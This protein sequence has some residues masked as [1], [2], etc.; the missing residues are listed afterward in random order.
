MPIIH[1][2]FVWVIPAL[3]ALG[4]F[5][6]GLWTWATPLFVY[7]LV[8]LLETGLHGTQDN[9]T[10]ESETQR[11][12]N[13]IANGLLYSL[14]PIQVLLLFTLVWR[15]QSFDAFELTGAIIGMGTMIGAIAINGAHE[16][17]HHTSRVAKIQARFMLALSLYPHFS[18]EHNKGHHIRMAT[19]EDPATAHSGQWVY[20]F[21]FQSIWGG[22][23]GAWQLERKRLQ[24]LGQ[25][26]WN[27]H[28]GLLQDCLAV[29]TILVTTTWLAGI[30]AVAVLVLVNTIGILLLETVNYLQ[31]YGLQR[32]PLETRGYERVGPAHSWTTN[33][34]LSRALLF[35]LPRHA[36]HHIDDRRHYTNLRHL[37]GSPVLPQGYPAMI[38][39]ALVP[40]LF[41]PVMDRQIQEFRAQS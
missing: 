8:P 16:L 29:L 36:D 25:P 27:L 35:D 9:I 4:L 7:G 20:A 14:L 19:P 17:G 28:N 6:G 39:L 11:S 5:L 10:P 24:R 22:L 38:L 21:W 26:H 40:P 37:D 31:H 15:L 1:Y 12:Q 33:R 3:V 23:K 32:S 18:V 13:S 34:P 41:L 2:A 30:S